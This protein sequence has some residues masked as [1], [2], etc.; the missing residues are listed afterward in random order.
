MNPAE[1]S[2]TSGRVPASVSPGES[3]SGTDR[4]EAECFSLDVVAQLAGVNTRTVLH[5]QAQGF[6]R[7]L[8]RTAAS[9]GN[10]RSGGIPETP[11]KDAP[12]TAAAS[13][14]FDTECLRQLR[15]IEH[16]RETCGVNDA[17]LRLILGLLEEVEHLRQLH[18]RT[19][20]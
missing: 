8:P 1:P 20:R 4:D 17:G 16:L 10:G 11:T 12:A 6:I 5:Y 14:V 18:R 15:R 2:P 9:P 7:P 3:A 13:D 19:M